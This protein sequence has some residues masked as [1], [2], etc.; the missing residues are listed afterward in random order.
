M[1]TKKLSPQLQAE[2]EFKEAW[3]KLMHVYDLTYSSPHAKVYR[4]RM[5]LLILQIR[6]ADPTV[7]PP[8]PRVTH[9]ARS[10]P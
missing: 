1:K 4:D 8:Q 2:E 3:A 5:E 10:K 7:K 6:N 9:Y